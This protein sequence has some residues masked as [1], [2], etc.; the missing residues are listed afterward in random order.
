MALQGE[1]SLLILFVGMVLSAILTLYFSM[2]ILKKTAGSNRGW[3][4]YAL[5]GMAN[6]INSFAGIVRSVVSGDNVLN[7]V[8]L[9]QTIVIFAFTLFLILAL[10][11]FAEVF[12]INSKIFSRRNI[13]IA[14]GIALVV[15]VIYADRYT[16][17]SVYSMANLTLMFGFLFSIVPIYRIM[18][19]T[20]KLPWKFLFASHIITIISLYLIFASIG[21]CSG[22]IEEGC[23]E[24]GSDS[25]LTIPA[26]CT[27]GFVGGYGAYLM[28]LLLSTWLMTGA[29]YLVNRGLSRVS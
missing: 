4:F 28:L 23:A 16:F 12:R 14:T 15:L 7:M 21:C 29:F 20:G 17:A 24:L 6:S 10:T 22:V 3:L 2:K 9:V 19:T 27:P 5:F 13:L 18:S 26:P 1:I 8:F 11:I 25:Y